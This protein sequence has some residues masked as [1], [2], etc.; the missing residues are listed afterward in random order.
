MIKHWGNNVELSPDLAK[1]IKKEVSVVAAYDKNGS[2][3]GG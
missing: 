2:N 1:D 3:K